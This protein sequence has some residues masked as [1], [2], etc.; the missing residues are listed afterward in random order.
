M[1][2]LSCDIP[3]T[4]LKNEEVDLK[5]ISNNF[6]HGLGRMTQVA[7]GFFSNPEKIANE[8]QRI[9]QNF[10]DEFKSHIPIL[11][12]LEALT[13]VNACGATI[14]PTPLALASSY[15]PALAYEMGNVIQKQMQA[16]GVQLALAPVSDV[17]RNAHWG[18]VVET[19][20]EDVLLNS[21]FSREFVL[22]IQNEGKVEAC[23]KHFLAYAASENG[24]NM[25]N[26]SIGKRELR[27][28]YARP[29]EEMINKAGLNNIMV[30]YCAIDNIPVTI[31]SDIISQLLRK[32]LNYKGVV[33]CDATSI[34]KSYSD[35]G[36]GNS[37]A[38][39]AK[40]ALENSIDA[41][42]PMTKSYRELPQLIQSKKTDQKYL[43]DSV[44]RVLNQKVKLGLFEQN[45]TKPVFNDFYYNKEYEKLS[46]KIAEESLI[47]LKNKGILPL[48]QGKNIAV[49]GP[50]AQSLT[51]LLG[52]YS[53]PKT[54]DLLLEVARH[55][56]GSMEGFLEILRQIVDIKDIQR[57]TGFDE[58]KTNQELLE[59]YVRDTYEVKTIR[60]SISQENGKTA[61]YAKGCDFNENCDGLADALEVATKGDIIVMALG[62]LNGFGQ[63][64]TSGE[65]KARCDLNLPAG[66]IKLIHE[67]AKLHKPMILVLVNGRALVISDIQDYFDAVIEVFINGPYGGEVIAEAIYGKFNPSGRL[68]ITIPSHSAQTPL[69]YSHHAGSGYESISAHEPAQYSDRDNKPLYPFG[70]GLSYSKFK[71]HEFKATLKDSK[72]IFKVNLENVSDCPGQEVIQIYMRHHGTSVTRPVKE[73]VAYKKVFVREQENINVELELDLNNFKYLDV[74]N[75]MVFEHGKLAFML[76]K[77]AVTVLKSV[78]IDW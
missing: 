65:G 15:N 39:V 47:L 62:G 16:L 42:T 51:N 1:A 22:G 72:V 14:F 7:T 45:K 71:Y 10:T 60:E 38:D 32:D 52:G 13:G 5:K 26:I 6:L 69:Y 2:Q 56:E 12:Q 4:Y 34:E 77:D 53:Y 50:H 57:V 29:F 21:D 9:Q 61:L 43:D 76:C 11:F 27:E 19:Y 73:L 20:G 68:P 3:L 70:F 23:A 67:V 25:S 41:D 55:K 64:A 66:Q 44:R 40:L 24:L 75:E 54:L 48:Q 37:L 58:N 33:L 63:D 59:K 49:I 46:K 28:V 74:K 36:I 8:L 31:N 30:T 35:Q 78:I 17:S 18:R